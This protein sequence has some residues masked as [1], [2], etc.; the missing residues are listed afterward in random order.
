MNTTN[1]TTA[2][3]RLWLA[4]ELGYW[5]GHNAGSWAIDG[6]TSDETLRRVIAGYDDG[7]PQIMDMQPS[8]LSGEW[9]DDPTPAGVLEALG[10]D[11][12]DDS[13]DELLTTYET[14]FSEGYWDEV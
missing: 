3:V 8:P 9:A 1:N 14:A 12:D 2:D 5:R 6:N 7:D 4:A 10:V 11:D 13:A